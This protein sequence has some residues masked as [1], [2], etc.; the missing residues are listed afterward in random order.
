M[1]AA[2]RIC[3][4]VVSFFGGVGDLSEAMAPYMLQVRGPAKHWLDTG[5]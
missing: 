1:T 5:C 2:L 3:W 4:L